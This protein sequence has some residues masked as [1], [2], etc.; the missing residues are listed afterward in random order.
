MPLWLQR[1]KAQ[2]LLQ[3]VREFPSFPILVET[4]RDVLQDAFDMPALAEVLRALQTG[5]IEL[6]EV[7]T[8]IPSPFASSLQFGFVMDFMY[9]DDTP[10]AEQRAAMLSLDR[11]LLDDLL[12][13]AGADDA[14]LAALDELLAVRRG[15]A[16]GRRARTAD[17]LAVLLDRAGDLTIDELHERVAPIADGRI[18]DPVSEL[19]E[20]GRAI[21]A[22]IPSADRGPAR[23]FM[24]TEAYPRYLAA[25]GDEVMATVFA[26]PS[27]L[28]L[29]AHDVV[30]EVLRRATLTRGAARRELLARF[31]ALS[32]PV[33]VDDVRRRYAFPAAWVEQ[34]LDEWSASGKL[35]RGS[36]ARSGEVVATR[37][38]S[39]RLLEQA[40]RRE[41]AAARRQ[42]E[43][44]GLPAFAH[45][46]Q[47]WQHLDPSTR[48]AGPEGTAAAIRQLYGLARPVDAWEREYLPQRVARYDAETI[49]RLCATGEAI[50]VGGSRLPLSDEESAPTL[51][52]LRFLRRGTGRA[53]LAETTVAPE[54]ALH[55]NAHRVLEALRR[56]G[57]SFFDDLL[58]ATG[59]GSRALRDALRELVASGLVTNDTVE[60]FRQVARWRPILSARMRNQP[61]PT[62]WLP[63][64]WSPSANR[65]VVQR[66][67]N[68]RRLPKW[69]PPTKE[70]GDPSASPWPGRWALVRTPGILG[71]ESEEAARAELVARQWLDRY[72]VVARDWWRRERPDV[73]WRAIYREL[74]RLEFRGEVRRGYFV[75]GLAGAQ[76][77]LPAAVE[78]LRESGPTQQAGTVDGSIVAATP[79][80]V[81]AASDPANPYSLPLPPSSNGDESDAA[82]KFSR[83][84]SRGALLATRAGEVLL[85][86]EGRGRRVSVRPGLSPADVA[87]AARVLAHRLLESSERR[88]DPVVETIDGA[89][90]AAS[91][92]ASAFVAAGFRVTASG[93]RFYAPPV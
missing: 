10:R 33:S 88:R 65:P 7:A 53:W 22:D 13:G 52:A 34:R 28:P 70:G 32:G 55:Q 79:I 47:R 19:L 42:I 54:E 38:C 93:L 27:L 29:P 44:V 89:G 85:V 87:E 12:G 81:M 15:T 4:Y 72:G 60:S 56:E 92:H 84:R 39:R 80:I 91:P 64:D 14:T 1:L 62:R 67:P 18:A 24:L 78:M 49:T 11:A 58:G 17:E 59:L 16:P 41:L 30:P 3:T 31:I 77:A 46:L 26:G 20:S 35:A 50:W 69:R 66:R 63:A 9:A 5:A 74:K 71:P 86:A 51:A 21:A 6:R 90:A 43:A 36:F 82:W 40:R 23:R 25:F 75:R 2:D 73:P 61:D 68:V 76:F 37:W 57:A 8:E 48:L 45:F 83:R